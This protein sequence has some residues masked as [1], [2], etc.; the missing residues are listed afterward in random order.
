M[1]G[2]RRAI[3]STYLTNL[4][5]IHAMAANLDCDV[6]IGAMRTTGATALLNAQTSVTLIKLVGRWR[7]D[8]V[9]RYFETQAD[10]S[11]SLAADLL[12]NLR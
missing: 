3:T 11:A 5:R 7:S 4:L 2:Q 8:E 9:M 10:T 6:T 1:A 12:A